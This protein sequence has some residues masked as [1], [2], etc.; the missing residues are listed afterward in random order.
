MQRLFTLLLITLASASEPS[1][2]SI[3]GSCLGTCPGGTVCGS[4]S[5]DTCE[6][7]TCYEGSKAFCSCAQLLAKGIIKSLKDCTQDDIVIACKDKTCINPTVV[8]TAA[9]PHWLRTVPQC[10]PDK[11]CGP[12]PPGADPTKVSNKCVVTPPDGTQLSKCALVCDPSF[13]Q[14]AGCP[15]GNNCAAIQGTGPTRTLTLRPNPQ[16]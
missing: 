15:P 16:C 10:G 7:S 1:C 8:A 2:E 5:H 12:P 6:C 3:A 9:E 14:K 11:P 4:S 13:G